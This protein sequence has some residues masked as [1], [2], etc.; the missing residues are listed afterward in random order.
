LPNSGSEQTAIT[1]GDFGPDGHPGFVVTEPTAA[2]SVV[3]YRR[4]GSA[5]NRYVIEPEPLHIED[6]GVAM[7]VDGDGHPDYI[8]A[9]L[10][11][12]DR[13]ACAC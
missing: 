3:L 13:M 12:P 4:V 6:G 5:W 10:R 8:A 9:G 7:D 1:I 2:D 11:G